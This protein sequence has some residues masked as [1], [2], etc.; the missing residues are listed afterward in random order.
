MNTIGFKLL[1]IA[2]QYSITKQQ[3]ITAELQ[4][5]KEHPNVRKIVAE[6]SK[7]LKEIMGLLNRL[8]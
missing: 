8:G 3:L 4:E 7:L 1:K 6:Q 2:L 5:F